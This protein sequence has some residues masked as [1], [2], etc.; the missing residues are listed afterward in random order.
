MARFMKLG[1]EVIYNYASSKKNVLFLHE[2]SNLE[3]V[4]S[5]FRE[6]PF[7]WL[8]CNICI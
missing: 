4:V 6:I 8:Y 2:C 5:V 3:N 7:L 1:K